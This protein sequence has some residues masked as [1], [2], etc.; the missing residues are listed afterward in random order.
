ME[1]GEQKRNEMSNTEK[2]A[3]ALKKVRRSSL[4]RTAR[5]SKTKGSGK[6]RSSWQSGMK[7]KT[8]FTFGGNKIETPP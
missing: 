2:V 1:E 8:N 4:R 6:K 7:I 3:S 5:F